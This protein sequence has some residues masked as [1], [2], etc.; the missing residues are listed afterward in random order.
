MRTYYQTGEKD[1]MQVVQRKICLLGDFSVGKTSL[2]RQYVEGLFDDK[3]LS[4]LG[5]KVSRKLID[6]PQK[7]VKLLL[8]D[9]A[10][11]DDYSEGIGATYLHGA[12]GALLVCDLTRRETL[13]TVAEYA[14]QFQ[15]TSGDAPIIVIANKVDLMGQREISTSELE[16]LANLLKTEYLLTSAKTGEAVESAFE[17][18]VDRIES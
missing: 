16:A 11:G 5:V 17:K 9:L 4:T 7:Q 12:V 2:V 6:R 13:S 10:G 18:L 3:Y 15:N 1:Y 14:K 8:W